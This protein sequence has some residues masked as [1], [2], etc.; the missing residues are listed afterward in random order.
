MNTPFVVKPLQKFKA[1]FKLFGKDPNP[2]AIVEIN[3]L[4]ASKSV[5][6]IKIKDVQA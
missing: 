6:D 5:T 1:K 2:N 4:L 3:N